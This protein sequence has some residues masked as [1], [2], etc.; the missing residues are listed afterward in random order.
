MPTIYVPDKLVY[1]IIK[2]DK[3]PKEF[4][5]EAVREK[6]EREEKESR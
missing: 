4:V 5:K 3:D 2:L 1:R 6:L